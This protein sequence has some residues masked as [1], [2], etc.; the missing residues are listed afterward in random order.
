MNKDQ[1]NQLAVNKV[2][3]MLCGFDPDYPNNIG[4]VLNYQE[5]LD[6][7]RLCILYQTFDLEATRREN[8]H[9]KELLEGPVEPN[10]ND[11]VGME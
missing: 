4:V 2:I 1:P 6:D 11:E 7:L 9:L 3:K 10:Q 5:T 8:A